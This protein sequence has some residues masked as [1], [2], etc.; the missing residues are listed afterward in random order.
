MQRLGR[1]EQDRASEAVIF[2]DGED[3][4][5]VQTAPFL[6]SFM[7]ENG[8]RIP[9]FLWRHDRQ[10]NR[11]TARYWN[12]SFRFQVTTW[13][14]GFFFRFKRIT[15]TRN[16]SVSI[17]SI[18]L[19]VSYQ[20]LH[21][22]RTAFISRIRFLPFRPKLLCKLI[23]QIFSLFFVTKPVF[24]SRIHVLSNNEQK[25]LGIYCFLQKIKRKFHFINMVAK[26]D[27]D[28]ARSMCAPPHTPIC[29]SAANKTIVFC[30]IN[31]KKTAKFQFWRRRSWSIYCQIMD[32]NCFFST[33]LISFAHEFLQVTCRTSVLHYVQVWIKMI[34]DVW[35]LTLRLATMECGNT[36]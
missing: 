18:P 8:M 21:F 7:K 16:Y 29:N 19:S 30:S 10:L 27:P 5:D 13:K 33:E 1:C 28:D 9:D 6:I 36:P 31:K 20:P 12:E 34:R 11:W 22:A 3:E 32:W 14:Q 17:A 2:F 25:K 4:N 15:C 35:R 23:F 26:Y 24:F